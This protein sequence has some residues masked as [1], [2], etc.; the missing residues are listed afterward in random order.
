VDLWVYFPLLYPHSRP[1]FFSPL[2]SLHLQVAEVS[3]VM[4]AVIAGE[5]SYSDVAEDLEVR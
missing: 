1:F 3:R 4:A 2:T 5:L